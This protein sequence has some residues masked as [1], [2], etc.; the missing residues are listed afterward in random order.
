LPRLELFADAGFPFTQWPDLSR[1]AVI[2][3]SAPTP[4]EYETLLDMAGFFGAQ[5]G[6]LVSGLTVAEVDH[7]DQVQNKDIVLIGTRD[8][9]P[10]LS[11][12]AGRMPLA[13][14]GLDMRVNEAAAWTRLL[15]PEW[16]FRQFDGRRMRGLL[17]SDARPDLLVESFVSPLRPDRMVVAIVPGGS[18]AI[19]AVR[20]LFTPSERQGPVYGGVAV[21]QNGRFESFLV[22]PL[23]YHA[24]EL[25]RYQYAT[26]LLIEYYWF[27]SPVVILLAVVIAAWVRQSTE[28]LAE[29]RLAA[30][31]T[32]PRLLQ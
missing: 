16:P 17:R 32:Q 14:A 8:S 27:I 13:L 1:T 25:D 4:T 31:E 3:P 21:S 30:P 23:A 15:H 19:D 2:M 7:L 22:G 29:R 9:Q 5:T 11:Q 6:A 24:G 18:S 20:A 28:R 10:L 26:V 12:W